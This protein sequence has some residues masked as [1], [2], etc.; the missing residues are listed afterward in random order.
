M[1]GQERLD[2]RPVGAD[3][4]PPCIVPSGVWVS[5]DDLDPRP[6]GPGTLPPCMVPWGVRSS[7][8]GLLVTMLL[9]VAGG[10][11]FRRLSAGKIGLIGSLSCNSIGRDGEI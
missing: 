8:D 4:L 5:S 10:L 7:L 2:P 11:Q 1:R 3:I 6:V 9:R